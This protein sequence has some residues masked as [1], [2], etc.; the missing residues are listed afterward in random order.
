MGYISRCIGDARA[1]RD[2]PSG[3][4]FPIH[5]V[6]HTPD[7]SGDTPR[8]VSY[9]G[10]GCFRDGGRVYL[11]R[12]RAATARL[13][14]LTGTR[15]THVAVSPSRSATDRAT[16]SS[17][18]GTPVSR[19]AGDSDIGG[20]LTVAMPQRPRA[21]ADGLRMSFLGARGSA[22]AAGSTAELCGGMGACAA[23]AL[24]VR[25][26][27]LLLVGAASHEHVL[28]MRTTAVWSESTA[29]TCGST[30]STL[31]SRCMSTVQCIC[32]P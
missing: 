29:E 2:T 8:G 17:R 22:V 16:R 3:V 28:R 10:C 18:V 32:A 12:G 26:S 4:V 23:Q 7:M 31:G 24:A 21:C 27:R 15:S 20:E 5:R 6:C 30:G 13:G 14:S 1:Y 11:A 9:T 25:L 19:V